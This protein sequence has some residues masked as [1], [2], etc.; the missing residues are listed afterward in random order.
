MK[1]NLSKSSILSHSQQFS[2]YEFEVT[3]QF[4]IFKNSVKESKNMEKLNNIEKSNNVEK[5]N[6]TKKSN[7]MKKFNNVEE[8]I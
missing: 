4:D 2:N 7:N 5:L 6:S 1:K 8:I 3:G